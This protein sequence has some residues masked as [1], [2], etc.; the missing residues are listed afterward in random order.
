MSHMRIGVDATCWDNN[1]GYGRHSRALLRAL[2]RLD[3]ANR[4]TCF[5]TR[6]RPP[7]RFRKDVKRARSR[8]KPR[9]P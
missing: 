9:P 4:Y 7:T 1:R 3:Q 8:R 2:V 6:R 5:S